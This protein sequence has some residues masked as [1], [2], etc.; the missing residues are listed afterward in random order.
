M[1]ESKQNY[2]NTLCF[3]ESIGV[4]PTTVHRNLCVNGHYLGVK[5]IKLPNGRL[6]W[7]EDAIDQIIESVNK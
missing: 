1:K 5:P 2:V 3:A 6:L 7:P 4:K